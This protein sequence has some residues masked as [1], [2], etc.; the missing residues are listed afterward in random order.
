MDF[1]SLRVPGRDWD[2]HK[3]H[4]AFYL[5]IR[6]V[7]MAV[8]LPSIFSNLE[9]VVRTKPNLI[10]QVLGQAVAQNQSVVLKNHHGI[11]GLVKIV[12][13]P[14]NAFEHENLLPLNI[15][16]LSYNNSSESAIDPPVRGKR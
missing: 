1:L 10:S 4:P 13:N 15:Q 16:V 6:A 2:R 7:I 5:A 3:V 11:R 14:V 12:S 9:N 8:L